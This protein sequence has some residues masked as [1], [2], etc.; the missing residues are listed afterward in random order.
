MLQLESSSSF[1]AVVRAFDRGR[2]VRWCHI[3]RRADLQ[4]RCPCRSREPTTGAG[5]SLVC[6][7]RKRIR[8][9]GLVPRANNHEGA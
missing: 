4:S 1:Q 6:R 2:P 8:D 7:P 5:C 3:Y 9:D